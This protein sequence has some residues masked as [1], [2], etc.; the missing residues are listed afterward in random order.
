MTS[1]LRETI[2]TP[3]NLEYTT[4]STARLNK[5]A[6]T[7]K[8]MSGW[9][10]LKANLKCKKAEPEICLPA[11]HSQMAQE[12]PLEQLRNDMKIMFAYNT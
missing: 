10:S 5:H 1:G 3:M 9:E 6:I 4:H 12:I 7:A 2:L 8:E 11:S